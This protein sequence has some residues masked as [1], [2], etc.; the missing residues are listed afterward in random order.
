MANEFKHKSVGS[1]LSQTEFESTGGHVFDS[2]AIGDIP[3]ASSTTQLSRLGIGG[4]GAVLTVTG[5]IPAWDTTWTPTGDLIPATDDSYDLGSASAAWQDLFL[6]GDITLTDAGTLATSAGGLT[7]TSAAAATWS[8]SAGALTITSAAAATWSTAAGALTLNGTGGVVLQE[9]GAAIISISDAR[10]VT[11]ANTASIALDASGVIELNSSGGALSIGN[12]N[13]DQTVNIATAGTRTLNIGIGD[14][15]DVTTTL[16]KGTLSVGVDD[17]G[18]D[19]IFYGDAASANMTWDTSEDD[20]ILNGAARIVIPDGQLVLAST[21]V[22]STAAE[23]NVLDGL[24]RGSV[25]YGNASAATTALAVGSANTVLISNGTDIAWGSI[26]VL[27]TIATGVWEGT[28]VGVAH[29]GTGVSTLLANAVLT[30]NGASAIQ[31]ESTLLFSSNK[32]IPT[33]SAHDAAGAVLTM[34]AG[35]TTAGTSNNQAGGA[36]TFQGGQGKGSGA[37]GNIVFQTANAAGSGSSLNAL[38]TA[39]TLSDDLSAAFAGAVTVAGNLTVNGTTTTVD[40]ATLAVEDPLIA[41]ASGNNA[42]DALDIGF[43]GL[44]DTSGSLDL[45]AGLFRDADDSGKWKLFKDL[46]A[47]PVATVNV[48]GTGYAVGTLVATLE[49]NAA[50]ATALATTRAIAVAGDV[51]GTADFDGT[52]AISITTTNA[53]A[54]VDFAHIQNVAAN[55]ILGRNANSSGVLS[56]IALATTTILIGDGTGFTA[57]A[58]SGDATMTNAGVVTV[59]SAAADFAV[60]DD[61]SLT[62]DSAVF[63]MGA[64][65]D[66]TITHDGTTGATLSGTPLVVDSLEASALV[67]DTY[68]G[69][70]LGFISNGTIAIGQAVYVHT[71]DGR[72]AL[73]QANAVGTMPA[74]GVAVTGASDGGA[75][76]ILVHGIYNDSDGFGGAQDEGDTMYVSENTAGLVTATIPDADGEFVQVMG[77]AVGPRD[78]YINPSLDIIERA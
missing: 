51:T 19:V 62:S 1:E 72:V 4:T 30:G 5:G 69:L 70:V 34:S 43:Y 15:T 28:D 38:A 14:G 36:L 3:Y 40:T 48:S 42:A 50:T 8:T 25:I 52:A 39:L 31:A 21:A 60:V 37:G 74:I 64:G 44:Y 35:A 68:S 76:K 16:V 56:E 10:A 54:S 49:G 78:V 67:N 46:Q 55:S 13:V 33:A 77:M 73:A 66:F 27:G 53:A 20:L 58:L 63:N 17:A 22:S 7:V 47:A 57:A 45:Y 32:L 65:N 75:I 29:G 11:T 6:E 9:G 41:L 71:A 2:Q 12:D 61:L 18:Y 26:T 24:A 23:L 59:A